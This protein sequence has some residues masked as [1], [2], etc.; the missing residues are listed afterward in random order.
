MCLRH[1][2]VPK[3]KV[4]RWVKNTPISIILFIC[5]YYSPDTI[6]S[7]FHGGGR[8]TVWSSWYFCEWGASVYWQRKRGKVI[9]LYH[10]HLTKPGHSK[11]SYVEKG[12]TWTNHPIHVS[13]WYTTIYC[14]KGLTWIGW[15]VMR[16][17][18]RM[19]LDYGWRPATTQNSMLLP[20][21]VFQGPSQYMVTV[22]GHCVKMAPTSK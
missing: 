7:A 8:S 9:F 19:S 4:D 18:S 2:K 10:A 22:V 20:S 16:A 12:L 3:C 15:L 6:C 5:S 13:P 1:S 14:V 11:I 21:D 17:W